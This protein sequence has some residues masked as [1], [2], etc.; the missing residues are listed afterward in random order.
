MTT[1]ASPSQSQ[2]P[3]RA[4]GIQVLESP[5]AVSQGVHYQDAGITSVGQVL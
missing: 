3:T 5:S 1:M 4:A 2:E